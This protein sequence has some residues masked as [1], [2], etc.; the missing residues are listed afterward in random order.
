VVQSLLKVL[1]REE[2][3]KMHDVGGQHIALKRLVPHLSADEQLP[4]AGT[5]FVVV[6]HP[7]LRLISAY[8]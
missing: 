5:T 7:F 3:A 1:G 6:R 8:R 2:L 4:D